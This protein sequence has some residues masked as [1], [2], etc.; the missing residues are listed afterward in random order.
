MSRPEDYPPEWPDLA[1]QYKDESA[2]R[3]VRCGHPHET[4]WKNPPAD[5]SK[6]SQ[7]DD[8]CNH[9]YHRLN[10]GLLRLQFQG[11]LYKVTPQQIGF[12][13]QRVLTVHHL[14]GDKENCRWWNCPPLCQK[15][16]LEV[17]AKVT[18]AQQYLGE[19]S[20]WFKPYLA[21]YLAFHVLGEDFT[22]AKIEELLPDLLALE[23]V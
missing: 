6:A 11:G 14:D 8:G 23:G 15:C 16:H 17:Q 13:P 18:M 12:V 7:C 3:C 5:P 19:H 10:E 22:R 21:G 9:H 1:K 4:T 2:W 20:E